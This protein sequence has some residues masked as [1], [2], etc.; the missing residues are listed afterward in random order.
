MGEF[1][2]LLLVFLIELK[3]SIVFNSYQSNG[4][5]N[6]KISKIVDFLITSTFQN[7]IIS[8][9]TEVT[10]LRHIQFLIHLKLVK[11]QTITSI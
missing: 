3:E 1:K 2:D 5:F 4:T 6:K 11:D 10:E 9:P 7:Q 8:E